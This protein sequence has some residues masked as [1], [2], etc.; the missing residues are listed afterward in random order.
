MYNYLP[1][2]TVSWCVLGLVWYFI[3]SIPDLCLLT[4]LDTNVDED[5]Y[6]ILDHTYPDEYLGVGM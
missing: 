3:V 5:S 1:L 2:F 6:Q 4:Y